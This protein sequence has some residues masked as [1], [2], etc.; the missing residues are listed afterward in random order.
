MLGRCLL[1]YTGRGGALAFVRP[2]LPS[3]KYDAVTAD[4]AAEASPAAPET[5]ELGEELRQCRI[6]LDVEAQPDLISP[7]MCAGSVRWVHRRCLD[8]WRAQGI[9]PSAFDQC[10]LCQFTYLTT[11]QERPRSARIRLRLLVAR[12]LCLV[13][14]GIQ[15]VILLQ[16][17]VLC[18][19]DV[20][21]RLV[22]KMPSDLARA[23]P[24]LA[25][26]GL[27]L[28]LVL[29]FIGLVGMCIACTMADA[30]PMLCIYDPWLSASTGDFMFAG[31]EMGEAGAACAVVA[32]CVLVFFALVG[33]FCSVFFASYVFTYLVRRHLTLSHKRDEARYAAVVDLATRAGPESVAMERGRAG[34]G[35]GCASDG[36]RPGYRAFADED[37]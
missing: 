20:R 28:I 8:E 18:A 26:Y 32:L 22:S 25:C 5:D 24:F 36:P 17:A 23:H 15:L 27:S 14:C 3:K 13:G 6:C 11:V 4:D 1:R 33:V 9:R 31:C 35:S 19:M 37:V 30:G 34:S 29:A 16:A 12:D 10:E 2:Y 7:C 21:G